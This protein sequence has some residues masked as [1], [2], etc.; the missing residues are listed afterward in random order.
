MEYLGIGYSNIR[1]PDNESNYAYKY[2]HNYNIFPEEVYIHEFL[3]TLERNAKTYGYEVP[4]LHDYSKYGYSEDRLEGL[5]KWY[6]AYMNQE[7]E[8]N[9]VKIGLPA[10]IYTYKPV[11]ESNFKYSME[12]DALQEP[13]NIIEVIRSVFRRVAKLFSYDSKEVI[14]FS[15]NSVE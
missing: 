7:I 1:L 12:V 11:H 5:K 14:E 15:D 4:D 8:H 3:H 13:K 9:G 10:E 6:I 2:N